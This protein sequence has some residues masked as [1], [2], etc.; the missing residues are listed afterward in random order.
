MPRHRPR[1]AFAASAGGDDEVVFALPYRLDDTSDQIA[2]IG[3]VAV[4]EHDDPAIDRCPRAAGET[5][6]TVTLL[7]RDNDPRPGSRRDLR[8]TVAAAA[9]HDD[10]FGRHVVRDLTDDPGDRRGLVQH[11]DDDGNA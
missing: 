5:S 2:A 9:I 3:A 11:R 10:D 1:L 6:P 4:H 8:R 7:A